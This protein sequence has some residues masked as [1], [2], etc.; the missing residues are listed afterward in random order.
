MNNAFWNN[1][2]VHTAISFLL[3]VLPIVIAHGGSLATI[4]V[5]AVLTGIYQALRNN[6]SGLTLGGSRKP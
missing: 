2:V 6:A 1:P 4:T 3:F 5:G